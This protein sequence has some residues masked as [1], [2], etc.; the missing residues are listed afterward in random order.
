MKT[1]PVNS[2]ILRQLWSTVEQTQTSTLLGL[3]DTDLVKQLL[4]QMDNQKDLNSE[5]TNT[6]SAYIYSK[7]LL[8]RDLAQ[9][10]LVSC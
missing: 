2:K 4:G 8:I 9:A 10:R 6:L 1:Y 5:E 7:I 3:N